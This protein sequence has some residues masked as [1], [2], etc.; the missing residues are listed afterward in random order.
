[1]GWQSQLFP[2]PS[3]A[4]GNGVGGA[5]S[6]TGAGTQ[7]VPMAIINAGTVSTV[8]LPATLPLFASGLGALGLLGLRKKRKAIAA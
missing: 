5:G 2:P 3:W 4:S 7:L 1:M 8:P 6:W